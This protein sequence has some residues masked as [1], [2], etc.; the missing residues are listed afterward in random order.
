MAIYFADKHFDFVKPDGKYTKDISSVVA[1]PNGGFLVGGVSEAC[2]DSSSERPVGAGLS[3]ART[4]ASGRTKPGGRGMSLAR[5][6][7]ARTVPA[8]VPAS[9]R[10]SHLKSSAG[11]SQVAER[12]LASLVEECN[13]KPRRRTGRPQLVQCMA[14]SRQFVPT[15]V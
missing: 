7:A 2:S 14:S 6:C 3:Q 9:V 12:Q 11:G 13:A 15:Q 10:K 4:S 8:R 5:T 1:D